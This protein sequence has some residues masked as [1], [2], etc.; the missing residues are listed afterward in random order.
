M[1]TESEGTALRKVE[2]CKTIQQLLKH[3]AIRRKIEELTQE[4][5]A[6]FTSS[7]IAIA[8]DPKLAKCSPQSILGAACQ[9]PILKLQISPSLGHA[10]IVPYG[11]DAQF[12][13]G[14]KG[15]IQLAQ[16]TRQYY[17]MKETVIPCG[18]LKHY[19]ELTEE[20]DLD[21]TNAKEGE[22]KGGTEETG[23]RNGNYDVC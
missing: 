11:K 5:K 10:H 23:C 8:T 9:A 18:V 6:H 16:R 15:F 12:Q 19:N 22:E 13:I 4:N 2:D 7:L 1:S 21:W 14:Y 3:P 20:L 17:R